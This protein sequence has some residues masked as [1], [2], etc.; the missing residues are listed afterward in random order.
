MQSWQQFECLFRNQ[1]QERLR[2]FQLEPLRGQTH[3]FPI[4]RP[5]FAANISATGPMVS[6]VSP[7]LLESDHKKERPEVSTG[8]DIVKSVS[9]P[10]KKAPK[11]GLNHIFRIETVGEVFAGLF[12]SQGSQ[13]VSIA[14]IELSRSKFVAVAQLDQEGTIGWIVDCFASRDEWSSSG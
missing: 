11:H 4:V 3:S 1:L 8:W 2:F 5:L 9:R 6:A 12:F 14:L 13:S 7:N 10:F